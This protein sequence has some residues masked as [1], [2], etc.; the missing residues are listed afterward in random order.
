MTSPDSGKGTGLGLSVVH[1]IM[2]SHG[3]EI[4]VHS[5]PGDGTTFGVYLPYATDVNDASTGPSATRDTKSQPRQAG[6]GLWRRPTT[7]PTG[8]I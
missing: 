4:I 2:E 3:G 1:G 5:E 7:L 6:S 8:S